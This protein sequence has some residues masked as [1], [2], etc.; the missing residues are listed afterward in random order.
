MVVSIGRLGSSPATADYYLERQAGCEA[1]YYT[2]PAQRRGRWLGDGAQALG[3]SGTLD[4]AGE[5]ALRAMLDGRHPDG[6]QLLAPSCGCTPTPGCPRRRWSKRS[7]RSP[8]ART[9][10]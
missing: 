2:S 6:R 5:D 9:S 10:T 1:D 4:Q 7:N 3:L 8:A